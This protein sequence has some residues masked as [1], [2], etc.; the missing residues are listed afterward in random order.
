MDLSEH[1]PLMV[2]DASGSLL[3]TGIVQDGKWLSQACRL[4]DALEDLF[5]LCESCLDQAH[6]SLQD[7]RGYLFCEGPGSML[8]IRI[9]AMAVNTWRCLPELDHPLHAYRS[10]DLATLD[11]AAK[12]QIE[13]L[14]LVSR[15][16]RKAYIR[17][18][19]SKEKGFSDPYI[20]GDSEL[21]KGSENLRE[22]I[23]KGSAVDSAPDSVPYSI[24]CLPQILSR[25][26]LPLY[27][28]DSAAPFQIQK[29]EYQRWQGERHR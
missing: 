19:W 23:L 26:E 27:A 25:A 4:G 1:Q 10:M 3:Q 13:C 2:L 24:E 6:M 20:A 22:L 5:T 15:L 16:R 8:G 18:D 14:S 11:I 7:L 12:E 28:I 17:T 29:P 21:D 9:A